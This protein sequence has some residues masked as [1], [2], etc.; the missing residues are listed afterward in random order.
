MIH[1]GLDM[2]LKKISEKF[3][4]KNVERRKDGIYIMM[5]SMNK[6]MNEIVSFIFPF[7]QYKQGKA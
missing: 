4:N 7:G 5:H 3:E 6:T 2:E 1:K